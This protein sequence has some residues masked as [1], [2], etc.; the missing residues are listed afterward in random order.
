MMIDCPQCLDGD[1]LRCGD[2]RIRL[3]GMDAP[4]M[5]ACLRWRTCIP[6][7]DLNAS[8]VASFEL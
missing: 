7:D 4:E 2:T 8:A 1:T 5:G 6:G 3:L